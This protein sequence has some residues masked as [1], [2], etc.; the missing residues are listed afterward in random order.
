LALIIITSKEEVGMAVKLL[1]DVQDGQIIKVG[2][3]KHKV[4]RSPFGILLTKELMPGI[5]GGTPKDVAQAITNYS[6]SGSTFVEVVEVGTAPKTDLT[7]Q[8]RA[9]HKTQSLTDSL[10][11]QKAAADEDVYDDEDY[12]DYDDEEEEDEDWDS[13]WDEEGNVP[14]YDYY[15]P[16]PM[17]LHAHSIASAYDAP[18]QIHFNGNAP[19]I[20][21]AKTSA[22]SANLKAQQAQ[23]TAQQAR[24]DAGV[25]KAK[26]KEVEGQVGYIRSGLDSLGYDIGGLEDRV[27]DL[28]FEVNGVAEEVYNVQDYA[29]AVSDVAHNAL[30][31]VEA[32]EAKQFEEEKKMSLQNELNRKLAEQKQ[33]AELQAQLNQKLN[34]KT[35]GGNGTMKNVLNTIKGQFGKVEGKFAFSVLTGGL[36]L[37]KGLT[38]SFVAYNKDTKELTDVSG[39]TLKFDVPAFKLPVAS[40]QVAVGDLIIHNGE[41]VY[42]TKK[43]D[44]YLEILNPEKGVNG[45]V[46]PTKNVLLN[47]AFYTVVKTLDAAGGTGFNPMLLMAMDKGSD[48]SDL[49]PLLLMSGG[50][51]NGAAGSIDPTMLMLLGD[52]VEDLLPLVLMQQGGVTGTGFNPLFFLLSQKGGKMGDMLPLLMATGGLNGGAQAGGFNPM[53]LLALGGEGGDM[54]DLLM[55][56]AL[57]GQNIFGGVA[58]VAPAAKEVKGNK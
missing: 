9:Q 14:S 15:S 55:M 57:T 24:F 44:G 40:E 34:Q 39:L 46:V 31:K 3:V 50:I 26:A 8:L 21:E 41:Y 56:Q 23:N 51:G 12:D 10:R 27:S 33:Q 1:K 25:A 18:G 2:G 29:Y 38:N 54:K 28:A 16:R 52:D 20:Q 37:R 58:P 45:S 4:S 19:E 36:A 30:R 22:L 32:I 13:A 49:L 6:G 11:A 47:A 43:N 48:K 17:N 7:S 53:M 35:T 5:F 42:V